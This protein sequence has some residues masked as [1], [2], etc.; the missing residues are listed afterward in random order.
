MSVKCAVPSVLRP[1][2]L[3][4]VISVM[5]GLLFLVSSNYAQQTTPLPNLIKFR[6]M[7]SSDD[8]SSRVDVLFSL[9]SDQFGGLP[10]WQEV[11]S[12][13]VDASGQ[14]AALLGSATTDGVPTDLF[15]GNQTRWVG[16]QVLGEAEQPRV[17][18]ASVPYAVKAAD[19]DTLGGLPASAF[20]RADDSSLEHQLTLGPGITGAMS[21]NSLT[22]GADTTFLQQR[23]T[24][25]CAAGSAIASI[26]PTGQVSCE[27]VGPLAQASAAPTPAQV[28]SAISGQTIAPVAVTAQSLNGVVNPLAY[29]GADVCSQINAAAQALSSLRTIRIPAGNY[30]CANNIS[31]L[32]YGVNLEGEESGAVTITLNGSGVGLDTAGFNVIRNLT[33]M[34]GAL[35]TDCVR[36][37]GSVVTLDS[38]YISG[39]GTSSKLIHIAAFN[40]SVASGAVRIK[41]GQWGAYLGTALYIDHAIDVH[42]DD[43]EIINSA[44]VTTPRAIVI[45]TGT[46]GVYAK[47]VVSNSSGAGALLVTNSSGGSGGYN[48]SPNYLFFDQFIAD[49]SSGGDAIRFDSSL[50]SNVLYAEFVNSWAAGA[51]MNGSLGVVTPSANGLG[52]YGGTGIKWSGKIRSNANN[53]IYVNGTN[54]AYIDITGFITGNNVGNNAD[55]QGIYVASGSRGIRVHDCTS[56]NV[57]ETTGHQ[58]Y[59][60][61]VAA[62]AADQFM[63]R[64]CEL[65][66]NVTGGYLIQ[67]TAR[68]SALG[69]DSPVSSSGS[70]NGDYLSGPLQMLGPIYG[71]EIYGT[72]VSS[73]AGFQHN[74][75]TIIP[76][77]VTG[78][79]G[80]DGNKVVLS[81]TPK[82]GHVA[83]WTITGRAGYCS[84]G[85]RSDGSCTCN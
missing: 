65:G 60:V 32:P 59:G 6:G 18:L 70:S 66:N 10:L 4:R 46:S 26:G 73:S 53:G 13:K 57:I 34:C 44:N 35:I 7:M 75:V 72:V 5:L 55:G 28:V 50:G 21:T 83:C 8:S 51:G 49:M 56:G 81:T 82:S 69:N 12:V 1:N 17:L 67:D 68:F 80:T 19:S 48:A 39:G 22:L 11:Q 40:S 29:P 77:T 9:Y 79:S 85:I 42:L 47:K 71:H 54:A 33:L 43:L 23:V 14:Y 24:G 30:T 76:G 31:A 38:F 64:N 61:K 2:H 15:S 27:S 37:R 45:D 63:L 36:L 78:Y 20:L 74:G 25:S 41:N 3:C 16:V 52:I 84:T 62:V 58:R